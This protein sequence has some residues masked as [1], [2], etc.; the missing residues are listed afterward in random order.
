[1]Q[2]KFPKI[3]FVFYM[4][5][6]ELVALTCLYQADNACQRLSM[7]EETLLGFCVSLKETFSNATT[8]TVL[9]K[10]Y[11]GSAIQIA[12]V[13]GPICLVVCLRVL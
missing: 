10:Y 4:I 6:S 9:N 3:F 5:A 2:K 11:K 7:S 8:F 12:T 13:F 1:M